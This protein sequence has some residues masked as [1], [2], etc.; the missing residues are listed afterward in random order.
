MGTYSATTEFIKVL[1]FLGLLL[2]LSIFCVRYVRRRYH[3]VLESNSLSLVNS[4]PLGNNRFIYLV[5]WEKQLLLLGV[6]EHSVNILKDK[7][8][9]ETEDELPTSS[10]SNR[11]LKTLNS[12]RSKL[13]YIGSLIFIALSVVLPSGYLYAAPEFVPVPNIAVNID[14]LPTQGGLGTAIGILAMLTVLALAPSIL[15]M[16]TSFTRIVIVF[17]FLR[18]GMGTQQSPPNQIL[19]GLAL[20]LTFFIMMPTWSTVNELA[21]TPYLEGEIDLQEFF[22]RASEPVKEFMLKETREK[23]LAIFINENAEN[24]NSPQDLSIFQVIPAFALSE[25]KTAF[26][27]GFLLFLPF[28]IVDMVVSSTLMAMGMLMLPPV[29]ISLPFKILLFVLVDGWNLISKS[30]IMGFR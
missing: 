18:A 19:V 25:L 4:L 11:H 20:L 26:E 9:E 22:E 5:R 8:A 27:M 30:L 7:L 14:G 17:S 13:K 23:D 21:L 24:I 29:L 10:T 16:T 2:C 6:T 3:S 28:L 12:H 1:G 15:I